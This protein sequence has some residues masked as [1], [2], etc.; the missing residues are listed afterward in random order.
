VDGDNAADASFV[1][2]GGAAE[3]VLKVQESLKKV[4]VD[5]GVLAVDIG[6]W[7][8]RWPIITVKRNADRYVWTALQLMGLST[9]STFASVSLMGTP[10]VGCYYQDVYTPASYV[11][12][13]TGG[14]VT[15]FR[16]DGDEI[17]RLPKGTLGV[18]C[19]MPEGGTSS[20][21]YLRQSQTRRTVNL[22]VRRGGVIVLSSPRLEPN[23]DDLILSVV[24][25]GA[26]ES[27]TAL[28]IGTLERQQKMFLLSRANR[29]RMIEM[30]RIESGSRVTA[31]VGVRQGLSTVIV[32]QVTSRAKTT[33]YVKVVVPDR[34]L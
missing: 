1:A 33:S 22:V 18:R 20:L 5:A 13:A 32:V 26:G 17:Q 29:W 12:T 24:P 15:L 19:G 27:P 25:R 14:Y 8:G 2:P 16:I 28:V 9:P 4:Q 21:F 23:F 30:P 10:L 3:V 34:L 31:A 7:Q 6:K 11:R